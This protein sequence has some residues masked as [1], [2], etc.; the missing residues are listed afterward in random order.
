MEKKL[1]GVFCVEQ[2]SQPRTWKV[3]EIELLKQITRQLAIAIKQAELYH[4]IEEA[5][6][7]L[8]ELA[9]ID[10]LTKIA[11]RR[12]FD[13]YLESEWWRLARE[14]APLSLILCD[15]DY[16]K[17]YNDT[18]GHQSGDRCLYQI[19]QAIKKTVKRPADLTAR[20]GGEELAVILPNTNPEGAEQLA[21]DIC[22]QIKALQIPHINSSADM[23]VTLSLG[24][25]GCIPE[26]GC[27]VE[28]LI[29]KADRNLYQAK[30]MGRNRVVRS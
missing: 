28:N 6:I 4:T 13:E 12:K 17:L 7:K 15:I 29:A 18:Y 2:S 16:F 19:A 26:H 24:V 11:N 3:A 25:A 1:W 9:V 30:E 10:S 20:Y 14:K 27:S 5:N 21:K 23:Y 22:R 8:Q